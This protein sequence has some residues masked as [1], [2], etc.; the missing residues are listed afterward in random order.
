MLHID[1]EKVFK[2]LTGELLGNVSAE[3]VQSFFQ[4]HKLRNC[5]GSAMEGGGMHKGDVDKVV[6]FLSTELRMIGG[7]IGDLHPVTFMSSM[8]RKKAILEAAGLP[9]PM[10]AAL[11]S[12]MGLFLRQKMLFIIIVHVFTLFIIF[13]ITFGMESDQPHNFKGLFIAVTTMLVFDQTLVSMITHFFDM[14]LR[15]FVRTADRLSK[16][17]ILLGPIGPEM[18]VLNSLVE[19]MEEVLKVWDG[20]KDSAGRKL[21]PRN[22]WLVHNKLGRTGKM[23][24]ILMVVTIIILAIVLRTMK[25]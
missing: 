22:P 4:E 6:H 12:V 23:V 3:T 25:K 1:A 5:I 8:P 20:A 7:N 18:E 21:F 13:W 11:A 14:S 10:A 9:P 16:W 2:G 17:G 24:T 15:H 19:K